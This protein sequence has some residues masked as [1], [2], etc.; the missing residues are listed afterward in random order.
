MSVIVARRAPDFTAPVGRI[1]ERFTLQAARQISC[2]VNEML[3][4]VETL[5]FTK[6]HGEVCPAGWNKNRQGRRPRKAWPMISVLTR[7]S[8]RSSSQEERPPK[9]HS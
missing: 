9:P 3:R 2:D 4:M 1:V 5:Q 7:T 8:C 6:A